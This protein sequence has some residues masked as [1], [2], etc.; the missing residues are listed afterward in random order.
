[1]ATT[2]DSIKILDMNNTIQIITNLDFDSKLDSSRNLAKNRNG[3]PIKDQS[4]V[5]VKQGIHE[6]IKFIFRVR[7]V[8]SSMFIR[9]LLLSLIKALIKLME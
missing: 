2:K 9:I 5:R 6:V 7:D 1:M 3:E 4:I 8:L